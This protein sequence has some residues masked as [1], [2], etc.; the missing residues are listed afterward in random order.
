MITLINYKAVGRR[1]GHYRKEKNLTQAALSEV[2]NVSESYMSQVER[3]VAK[4]SLSRL[5]DI[6][7]ALGVDIAYLVSD[8]I[9]TINPNVNSEI[10]EIT[11]NWSDK[12]IRFLVEMLVCADKQFKVE[13]EE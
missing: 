8:H 4:V 10:F 12:E 3:G 1:I 11:K 7:D 13:K 5:S 9:I 6:A 2:L